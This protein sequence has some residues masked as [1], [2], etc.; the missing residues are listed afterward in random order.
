MNSIKG[1]PAYWKTFLNEFLVMVKRLGLP[2]LNL[3]LFCADLR[4]NALVSLVFKIIINNLNLSEEEVQ[5]LPYQERCKFLN[6]NPVLVAR[7][8]QFRVDV[9][10]KE[11]LVDGPL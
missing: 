2:T 7:H 3:T 8:F 4:W 10:F 6:M 1:T 11:I 9:F 5:N